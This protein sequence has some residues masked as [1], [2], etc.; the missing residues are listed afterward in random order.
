V[1]PHLR[2]VAV[3]G[4]VA[5]IAVWACT[6]D[7][8]SPGRCDDFCPNEK[9]TVRDTVLDTAITR[10]SAYGRPVGY[11]N[12]HNAPV[13]IVESLPGVRTS[14]AIFRF[15]PAQALTKLITSTDTAPL[16][17]P[18]SVF[19][20]IRV[21]RHEPRAT[22][23]TLHI[24]RMPLAMDSTTTFTDPAISDSFAAAPLR[25]VNLDTLLAFP[26]RYDSLLA[27]TVHLDTISGDRVAA[28]S[29]AG[30]LQFVFALKFDSLAVPFDTTDSARAAFGIRVT[31]D[32]FASIAVGTSDLGQGP[33]LVW[34]NRYDSLGTIVHFK[35]QAQGGTA[36]ANA[37][38]GFVFTPPTT[39]LDSNLTVGGMPEARSILRLKL[40]R[41]IVDST[42]IVRATLLLIP[43]DSVRGVPSDSF[44]LLAHGTA[45]DVGAKSPT[46]LDPSLPPDSAIVRVGLTDTVRI[47]VTNLLRRWQ[48]DT[49]MPR[50][51]ILQQGV[52][53]SGLL[54][55]GA[56]FAEG[57]FYSSRAALHRPRLH[58]TYIPRITFSP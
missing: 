43:S 21:L 52:F 15:N 11:I 29:V 44:E 32:S 3:L 1:T 9:I 46:L 2:R 4:L 41:A 14:R 27:D 18:D 28:D 19:L 37:Y 45:L 50:T 12:P 38:D 47:D 17:Q 16:L 42:Q 56:E 39:V 35:Q 20:I 58:I 10:D 57:R 34:I 54:Y 33:R 23:L 30:Q 6:D 26:A 53:I 7:L 40:P 22:N 36:G 48:I 55:N 24:Y 5:A 51:L 25:S 8:T 49:L 31:A 13:M